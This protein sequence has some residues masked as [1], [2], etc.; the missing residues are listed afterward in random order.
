[1]L[2]G[3]ALLAFQFAVPVAI[4]IAILLGI[5]AFSYRQICI[6]YPTGGG[7][8]S[9]SKANF[10]RIASLVA[11]SALLIDY[12]L[13]VAVSTSSA[14]EQI[15]SA[16]PDLGAVRGRDRGRGDRPDH[17]RQPA[18]PP[19]GRQHLRGPDLPVPRQRAADDRRGCLPDHRARRYPAAT[20]R[21]RRRR[22]STPCRPSSVLLL[23]RAFASGRRCPDRYRGDRDRRARVQAARSEE[24]RDDAGGDG[25]HPRRPVHRDHV[26]G[27]QLR[28]RAG[29]RADQAD[30]HRAGVVDRVRRRLVRLL[31]VPGLHR[32]AAVPRR[33]HVL[34]GLPAARRGARRSTASS[35]ASSAS[36]ATGW[37]SRSGIVVAR[38]RRRFARRHLRRPHPRPDPALR[39]RRVHR[40]HDPP[41]GHGPP[42]AAGQGPRLAA[43]PGDQR[44]RLRR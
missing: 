12:N 3:A 27:R 25:R 11:A 41:G 7:S 13:T 4:A 37:R 35:P 40:L 30:G 5:V 19:R 32:A 22:P 36:A 23:L 33:E 21:G 2:A 26:P 29:R 24:R 28:D 34:R 1:M 18:R 31:P 8:Y 20:A 38:D 16:L 42:L 39:G 17:D 15:T 9:V 14:V 44:V 10:G 6:A 43:T